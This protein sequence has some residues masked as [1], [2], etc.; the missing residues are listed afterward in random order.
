MLERDGFET[1]TLM[2]MPPIWVE[3]GG[4]VK[5]M[6]L[7][8][9]PGTGKNEGKDAPREHVVGKTSMKPQ[10]VVA[11]DGATTY[12][13]T[14]ETFGDMFSNTEKDDMDMLLRVL[15]LGKMRSLQDLAEELVPGC[16]ADGSPDR[17]YYGMVLYANRH[18]LQSELQATTREPE[19]KQFE[20][21]GAHAVG[22]GTKAKFQSANW[23]RTVHIKVKE[24]F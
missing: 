22:K 5:R 12:A 2:S 18:S 3:K 20:T 16:T 21:W 17:W 7:A 24:C 1:D 23:P 8:T 4:T 13:L 19:R 6:G 9:L 11:L 10:L 14:G 15:P